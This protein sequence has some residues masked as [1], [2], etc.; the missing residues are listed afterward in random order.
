M[1]IIAG[2]A[3]APNSDSR[4]E[5]KPPKLVPTSSPASERKKRPPPSSAM[6]A[7]RSADQEKRSPVA[8]VGINATATQVVAKTM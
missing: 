7:M 1:T 4:L 2:S 8:K 3:S 6:M 5:P